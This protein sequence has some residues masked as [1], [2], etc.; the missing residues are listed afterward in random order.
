MVRS[1]QVNDL[2]SF[3]MLATPGSKGRPF[4]PA[5]AGLSRWKIWLFVH[6]APPWHEA[7]LA[8]KTARPGST[9][10]GLGCG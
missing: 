8:A 3:D 2:N 10:L 4:W 7:Q 1:L 6:F 5:A 9:A